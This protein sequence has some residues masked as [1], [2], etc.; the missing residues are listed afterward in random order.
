MSRRYAAPL[1]RAGTACRRTW[2]RHSPGSCPNTWARAAALARA[3]VAGRRLHPA[4]CPRWCPRPPGRAACGWA[5]SASTSTLMVMRRWPPACTLPTQR[6]KDQPELAV[7]IPYRAAK[8]GAA[9]R[10]ARRRRGTRSASRSA[11][12]WPAG[13]GGPYVDLLQRRRQLG[14]ARCGYLR[15]AGSRRTCRHPCPA[16]ASLLRQKSSPYIW[17]VS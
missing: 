5:R 1:Y 11:G 2:T 8:R 9:G 10:L 4:P 16:A 12:R 13:R 3:I 6:A 17:R 14:G 7:G 15:T